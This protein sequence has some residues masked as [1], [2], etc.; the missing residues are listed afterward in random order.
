MKF[1][2]KLLA[3][4]SQLSAG[5]RENPGAKYWIPEQVG[6]DSEI[7]TETVKLQTKICPP[8]S[9]C[10]ALP[11]LLGITKEKKIVL[12]LLPQPAQN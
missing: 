9:T 11:D 4:S 12:L 2:K 6:N 1:S 3:V 7:S 5:P 8:S 10:L